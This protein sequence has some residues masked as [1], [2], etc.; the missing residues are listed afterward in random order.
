MGKQGIG[1]GVAT[2]GLEGALWMAQFKVAER[3]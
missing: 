2:G 1:D 3:I